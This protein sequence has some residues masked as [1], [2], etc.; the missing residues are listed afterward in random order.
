MSSERKQPAKDSVKDAG[1]PPVVEG[2]RPRR[3]ASRFRRID[4]NSE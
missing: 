2:N 4:G 1:Q 3:P